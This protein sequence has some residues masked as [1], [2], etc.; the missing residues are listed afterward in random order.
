V[1]LVLP[2]WWALPRLRFALVPA[3]AYREGP[4][5]ARLASWAD[6]PD[7]ETKDT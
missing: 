6:L 7:E 1:V 3:E 5:A 2:A 4:G